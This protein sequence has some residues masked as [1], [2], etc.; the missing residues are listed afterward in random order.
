MKYFFPREVNFDSKGH[1]KGMQ[2]WWT[3]A[4][5]IPTYPRSSMILTCLYV[6]I[7]SVEFIPNVILKARHHS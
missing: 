1:W 3:C 6:I 5:H 2:Y 4:Y 7:L